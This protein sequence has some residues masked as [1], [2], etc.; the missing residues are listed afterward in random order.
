VPLCLGLLGQPASLAR[1]ALHARPTPHIGAAEAPNGPREG[2]TAHENGDPSSRNTKPLSDV[3]RHDEFCPRVDAHATGN[4]TRINPDLTRTAEASCA[5]V[6]RGTDDLYLLDSRLPELLREVTGV[7]PDRSQKHAMLQAAGLRSTQRLALG[8]VG[9]GVV[10]FTW[11][12]ELVEQAE[13]LYDGVRA[14]RLLTATRKGSREVDARPHLA[15]WR[16]SPRM[17]I[18]PGRPTVRRSRSRASETGTPAS[19]S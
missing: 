14:P 2:G 16:S 17:E 7:E 4:L 18:P 13:Y 8:D 9:G 12:A 11:P 3:R 15:F 1:P 5:S 19:T 10:A 6:V